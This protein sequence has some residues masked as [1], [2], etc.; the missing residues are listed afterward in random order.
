MCIKCKTRLVS[1]GVSRRATASCT[2]FYDQ[3]VK[4]RRLTEECVFEVEVI[5]LENGHFEASFDE[6]ELQF[7]KV[8]TSR[9]S[10]VNT[11]LPLF[12]KP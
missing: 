9:T 3:Y 2:E 12:E 4:R 5:F 1:F 7:E 8:L 11:K 6:T 10:P